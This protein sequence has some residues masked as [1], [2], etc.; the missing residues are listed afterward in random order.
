MSL[1]I[2]VSVPL[3]SSLSLSLSVSLCLSLSHTPPWE[4]HYIY[5]IVLNSHIQLILSYRIGVETVYI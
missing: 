5:T 3:C 2:F 4:S 1:A